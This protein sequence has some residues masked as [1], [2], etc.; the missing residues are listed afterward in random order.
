[1]SRGQ[2]ASL[3]VG[4]IVAALYLFGQAMDVAPYYAPRFWLGGIGALTAASYLIF[5]R[6]SSN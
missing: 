4:L 2:R 6:P 3:I 1:M 5:A